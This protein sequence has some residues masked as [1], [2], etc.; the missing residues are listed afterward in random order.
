MEQEGLGVVVGIVG[1][2]DP[3]RSQ[4]AGGLAEEGVPHLAGGFLHTLAQPGG[5]GRHVAGA[6]IKLHAVFPAPV[7]YKRLVPIGLRPPQA[8][9]IVGRGDRKAPL[10]PQPGGQVKQ[11]HGVRPAGDGAEHRP[12][13]GEH[14]VFAL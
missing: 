11:A 9:V 7:S 8:M 10:G 1:R 2:G 3:V 12:A 13:G 6:C 14:V 5:P 4:A